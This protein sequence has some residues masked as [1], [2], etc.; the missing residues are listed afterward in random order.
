MKVNCS[1]CKYLISMLHVSKGK[2]KIGYCEHSCTKWLLPLDTPYLPV[3][4]EDHNCFLFEKVD[5]EK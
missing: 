3:G 2:E 4:K 1:D 5:K